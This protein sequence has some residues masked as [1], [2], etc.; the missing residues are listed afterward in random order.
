VQKLPDLSLLTSEQKDDLI[1]ALFDLQTQAALQLHSLTA[2]IKE[3]ED[4]LSKTSR[5]SSKPPSSDGLKKTKSQRQASGKPVGGQPGHKGTTLERTQQPDHVI[6]H[7]VPKHC[8]ACNAALPID[9]AEV[10]LR[11]QVIDLPPVRA[12]VTEH[13]TL[14]VRCQCGQQHTSQMPDHVGEAAVQYGPN[15]R[16][17]GVYLTHA[18]LLPVARTAQM[19]EEMYQLKVSPATVLQWGDQAQAVV[20]PSVDNIAAA[21]EQASVAHADES[22]L[23]IASKLQWL[24]TVATEDLTWYGVHAKRGMEA[25]K[26]HDVL[27]HFNGVLVHDCWAPYW[28]LDCE[29]AL[30][31][32][33]LLRELTFAHES[34]GQVWAKRVMD[35]LLECNRA[36]NQSAD[37]QT[38]LSAQTIEGL[39]AQ[40][41]S[42]LAQGFEQNPE[43]VKPAGK[44]GRAKQS[45][46]YNLLRRLKGRQKEVLLFMHKPHVP[47]TNN[48]AERAIRMP[49]VKQKISGCFRTDAGAQAFCTIRS[50]LDTARKQGTQMLEALRSAFTGKP[51]EFAGG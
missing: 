4:Q 10:W 15:I 3:L 51:V 22:G 12:E 14:R 46:T 29:H 16:A 2:R 13:Q 18:Q 24:H 30:C 39:T 47:F 17:Q 48:L 45:T 37:K 9:Q 20:A 19:L 36:V 43:Q 42:A 26:Y 40:F 6:Q 27:T 31:N 38:Q 25:I 1:R 32:A 33:H 28:Q 7:P 35:V 23:R 50:Y 49:K 5:N 8:T 21:I 34:T 41:E 11:A 44:K